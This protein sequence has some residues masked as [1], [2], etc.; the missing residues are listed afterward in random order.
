GTLQKAVTMRRDLS[1]ER[2]HQRREQQENADENVETM[3]ARQNKEARTHD[4]G[5]IEPKAFIV[6][7]EPLERLISKEGRTQKDREHEKKFP[8]LS[9]LNQT[10]YGKVQREAA[11]NKA[12]GRNDR[13]DHCLDV[14]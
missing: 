1:S 11:R 14:P 8:A 10:P 9:R 6:E 13:F 5:R 12:E 2:P 7:I 3:E 4:P